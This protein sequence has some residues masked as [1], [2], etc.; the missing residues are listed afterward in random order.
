MMMHGK[1]KETL[2]VLKDFIQWI[3]LRYNLKVNT[4]RS[5]NE[6]KRRRT[7]KWLQTQRIIFKSLAP[8]TQAQNGTTKHLEGVIIKRAH[9]MK[10]AAN[11]PH[12][13]WNK[14]VDC[15]VY[16]KDQMP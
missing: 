12:N 8:N 1:K 3:C 9:A 13:L 5:D 4:I 7:L 11:L 15:A 6:L 16:L 2:Q 14:I 10:I